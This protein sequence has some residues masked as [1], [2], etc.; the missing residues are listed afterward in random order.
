MVQADPTFG[1]RGAQTRSFK[2]EEITDK[3]FAIG[4]DNFK[5]YRK[6][7]MGLL[8]TKSP[9]PQVGEVWIITNKLG[10]WAFAYIS[11]NPGLPTPV[12]I[13]LL[14]VGHPTTGTWQEGVLYYSDALYLSTVAGEPGT[15]VT[16]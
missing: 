4:S 2:I 9:P 8:P 3:G 5:Q 12:I 14:G 13:N 10:I 1:A 15:W 6:I 11:N 16:L 7:P